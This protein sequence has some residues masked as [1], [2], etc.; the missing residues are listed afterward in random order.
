VAIRAANLTLFDF[1]KDPGPASAAIGEG[2][3][4]GK[5]FPDV[6][7]FEDDNVC[8]PAVDAWM[9]R[10][11]LNELPLE[12]S[13]LLSDLPDETGL[14]T[15]MVLPIIPRVRFRETVTTPGLQL[16]LASPHRRKRIKRLHFAALRARS[17]EGERA[18]RSMSRE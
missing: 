5:L 17:H 3:N 9:A 7:E 15:L 6:I 4:V 10:E 18:D 8:L 11:I 13:A 2:R 16:R 1:R 14:F 12:S